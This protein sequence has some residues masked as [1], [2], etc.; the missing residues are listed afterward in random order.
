MTDKTRI[1]DTAATMV[2]NAG[3]GAAFKRGMAAVNLAAEF[4]KRGVNVHV[5]PEFDNNR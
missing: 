2:Q 1:F 5:Q 4:G 3:Q